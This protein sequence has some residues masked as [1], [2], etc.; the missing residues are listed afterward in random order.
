MES[1]LVT[2]RCKPCEGGVPP[3]TE[4]QARSM[5]AQLVRHWSIA[6]DGKSI[7]AEFN[8]RNYYQTQAL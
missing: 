2:R 5:L 1:A 4:G 6:R 8:F 7:Q 3:L